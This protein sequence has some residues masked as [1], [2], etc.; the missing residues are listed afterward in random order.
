MARI[1][2][3]GTEYRVVD[4]RGGAKLLHLVELR[5]HTRALLEEPIG[6]GRLDEMARR[7]QELTRAVKAA[8]DDYRGAVQGGS[9]PEQLED[10]ARVVRRCK[11][12][13]ADD[14]LLGLAIIVFLS[15]RAAGDRVTFA[16]ATS[17]D[18]DRIEFVEEPA[19]ARVV[20]PAGDDAADPFGPAADP[21]PPGTPAA[22]GSRATRGGGRAPRKSATAAASG[23]RSTT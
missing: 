3:D 18:V 13:Q 21:T 1:R 20:P 9:T 11:A 23:G 17:V 19:D 6:M 8:E 14:G 5:E 12:E 2:I 16:Q 15:R 7:A 4:H 22:R 10:L